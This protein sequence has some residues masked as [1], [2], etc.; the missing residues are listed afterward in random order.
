MRKLITLSLCLMF[1]LGC[2]PKEEKSGNTDLV[3]Q[4]VL[5]DIDT[6]A[7][8]DE[9]WELLQKG[10]FE[11]R[12]EKDLA[13]QLAQD[14][15]AQFLT[16]HNREKSIAAYKKAL[17]LLPNLRLSDSVEVYV[18]KSLEGI[19]GKSTG[20]SSLPADE[21]S[22]DQEARQQAIKSLIEARKKNITSKN[23]PFVADKTE[24]QRLIAQT[25]L[26]N[27]LLDDAWEI[28]DDFSD[29]HPHYKI[30]RFPLLC[31]L[32]NAYQKTGNLKMS[33]TVDKECRKM[34]DSFPQGE[35]NPFEKK[36]YIR[37]LTQIGD[38]EEALKQLDKLQGNGLEKDF[39]LEEIIREKTRAGDYAKAIELTDR[40]TGFS[41]TDRRI[42]VQ[43][44][45]FGIVRQQLGNNDPEKATE[46]IR[47]IA[48]DTKDKDKVS[49]A[50]C[51]VSKALYRKGKRREADQTLAEAIRRTESTD[52]PPWDSTLELYI[53]DALCA[54]GKREEALTRLCVCRDRILAFY[55]NELQDPEK[56]AAFQ[57]GPHRFVW[58]MEPLAIALIR[59][60]DA[61]E[62]KQVLFKIKSFLE[63]NKPQ[64][65]NA[66]S[67]FGKAFAYYNANLA[68]TFASEGFIEDAV[69]MAG[70]INLDLARAKALVEIVKSYQYLKSGRPP[71][72]EV[73]DKMIAHPISEF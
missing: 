38:T 21:S 20:K 53:V 29:S 47:R 49:S 59:A 23:Y 57:T 46:T 41:E 33:E 12:Q 15:A 19:S 32:R 70:Q 4:I 69:E 51:A 2:I 71:K 63:T 28:L 67:E 56:R 48:D 42:K 73:Y 31:K 39:Y 66:V 27:G 37:A 52:R 8:I 30:I 64:D 62:G 40:I 60:G 26:D 22:T 45:L 16:Q 24:D 65:E 68:K 13:G 1:F 5:P 11:T 54:H 44:L 3:R 34:L 6:A 35:K 72:H 50:F 25:A 36:E 61:E 55:D 17:E 7:L 58:V 9:A 43:K 14:L 10:S 18:D